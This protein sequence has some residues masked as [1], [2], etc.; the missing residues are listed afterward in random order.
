M[1]GALVYSWTGTVPGRED[2][3]KALMEDSNA[4]S[5]KLVAEG[6]IS[7]YA[8]YLSTQGG[9]SYFIVRGE[10]EAL[11]ANLAD[12]ELLALNT[13]SG[14]INLD[15]RWGLYVTGDTVPL[16]AGMFFQTASEL[17]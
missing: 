2:A 15:F 5:D 11:M 1:Q 17:A 7:D 13:R 6:R 3:S 4:Y 9:T 10:T 16:M 8:W 14:L 12:P